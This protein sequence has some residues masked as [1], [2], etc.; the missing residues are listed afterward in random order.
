MIEA[1]ILNTNGLV[2]VSFNE[3]LIVNSGG[4]EA[5]L[6]F[7]SS[8]DTFELRGKSKISLDSSTSLSD[9]IQVTFVDQNNP[10]NEVQI[11]WVDGVGPSPGIDTNFL[12]NNLIQDAD[13]FHTGEGFNFFWENIREI[14]GDD[15][16]SLFEQSRRS[17]S[18]L[19]GNSND[20]YKQFFE[21]SNNSD[22]SQS[23]VGVQGNNDDSAQ[24]FMVVKKGDPNIEQT[25]NRVYLNSGLLQLFAQSIIGNLLNKEA[26]LNLDAQ[27]GEAFLKADILRINIPSS[28]EVGQV[29]TLTNNTNKE[30]RYQFPTPLGIFEVFDFNNPRDA[31][32]NL[33]DDRFYVIKRTVPAGLYEN[34]E[35]WVSGLSG[36]GPAES[37]Q[38]RVGIYGSNEILLESATVQIDQ[39]I[40]AGTRFQVAFSSVQRFR[41]PTDLF[42]VIGT[43]DY[44]GSFTVQS[45]DSRF[46]S[47]QFPT[48]EGYYFVQSS[49]PLPNDLSTVTKIVTNQCFYQK[50]YKI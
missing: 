35:W 17:I 16:T 9:D 47:S 6:E 27:T 2:S 49:G 26:F 31:T 14:F 7:A 32:Q 10:A 13:R 15:V 42:F 1:R 19:G 46:N 36:V 50:I 24:S 40:T 34:F 11:L 33:V 43:N 8:S 29:L 23:F 20:Q 39:S 25:L 44:V 4:T 45:I 41:R 22:E 48:S 28:L 21:L 37:C 12:N 5:T 3:I 18:G 30:N 38:Y